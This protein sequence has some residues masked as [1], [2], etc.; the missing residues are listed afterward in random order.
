MITALLSLGVFASIPFTGRVALARL[1]PDIPAVARPSL[2]VAAGAALWS[3]PL[4]TLVILGEYQPESLGA[5]GW[6]LVAG[7]LVTWIRRRNGSRPRAPQLSKWD[8]LVVAGVIAAA[9]LGGIFPSD[10][11]ASGAD[12]NT[13]ASHA[14][15]IA[16]HGGLGIANPWPPGDAPPAGFTGYPGVYFTNGSLTVQF[17]HLFPAWLAQAFSVGGFDAL[18]RLNLIIG[19]FA[20]LAIYGLA[21]RLVSSNYAA[22]AVLFLAFN[23]AQMWVARQALTEIPAQLFVWSGL[24]LL[25][26]YLDGGPRHFALW[27]GALLG[28]SA[29]IRI[30]AFLLIPFLLLGHAL[31][32]VATGRYVD[33]PSWRPIYLSSMPLFGVAFATYVLFSR[34]YLDSL[35]TQVLMIAALTVVSVVVLGLTRSKRVVQVGESLLNNRT[36]VFGALGLLAVITFYAYFIRPILPP[37]AIVDVP[38]AAFD[39][40]RSYIEDSL[41]NLG[42]YLTPGVVW[43]ALLGWSLVFLG[44]CRRHKVQASAVPL[45]VVLMG[46][47]AIYI[48]KQSVF[49]D[50]FWAI[51]RY[52]PEI[53][54]GMVVFAAVGAA[55]LLGRLSMPGRRLAVVAILPLLAAWTIYIGAPMYVTPER[56]GSYAAMDTF[57]G[58]VPSGNLAIAPDGDYEALH[59]WMPLLLAFDRPIIPLDASDDTARG[60]AVA[61]VSA[62]SENSP[63]TIV[64]AAYDYRMDAV[65]GQVVSTVD[66]SS[67][68][69]AETTNPVPRTVLEQDN[70]LVVIRATGLNTIGVPFGGSPQ[71]VAPGVG[72]HPAQLVDGRP[73][74]WTTGDAFLAIPVEGSAAASR[75]SVSIADTG[76]D[77]GPLRI[78][79]NGST[80]FDGVV[81]PGPWSSDFSLAGLP[82]LEVGSTANVEISSGTFQGDPVDGTDRENTFG[83][84]VD[85]VMLQAGQ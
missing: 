71:W 57:A 36:F 7:L 70:K 20:L 62:A 17:A 47:A 63:V 58:E 13:Y 69:M 66:W 83:V 81:A 11:F 76:P 73:L 56:A 26:H 45:L 74:R 48:W 59:Y 53:I 1:G 21:K 49:P 42:R 39:G 22:I 82:G 78:T 72:F 52:V 18:V 33:R 64:T 50:H 10:P 15:Y 60:S 9:V 51:R 32:N 77:G 35:L 85:T 75:L 4:L 6:L 61:L 5:L 2:W 41:A 14:I 44:V 80:I 43:A 46:I 55:W 16:H 23:P 40:Q 54:P 84:Q 34:P 38:G 30:D 28:A 29:F 37:F 65:V 27:A 19:V 24:L 68:V 67:P 79:V 25:L 31:W 3:I 8:W 12:M